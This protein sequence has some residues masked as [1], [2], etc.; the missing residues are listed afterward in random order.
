MYNIF[1]FITNLMELHISNYSDSTASA[2]G[3]FSN[4]H[5]I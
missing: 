5:L 1:V 3:N 2:T 4:C